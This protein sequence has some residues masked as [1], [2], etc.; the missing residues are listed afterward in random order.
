MASEK[1]KRVQVRFCNPLQH[2]CTSLP[3]QNYPKA[4]YPLLVHPGEE[5]EKERSVES[6]RVDVAVQG[7]LE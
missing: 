1:K 5:K 2:P 6:W 4:V 7:W 3:V